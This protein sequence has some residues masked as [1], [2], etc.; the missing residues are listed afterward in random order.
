MAVHTVCPYWYRSIPGLNLCVLTYQIRSSLSILFVFIALQVTQLSFRRIP[1]S[2]EKYCNHAHIIFHI[3]GDFNLHLDTPSATTTTFID[4]LA[5]FDKKQ[6]VN[7]PTDIHGHWL[8]ILITRSSCKK[9][10]QTPTVADGLSDP[11]HSN[12]RFLKFQ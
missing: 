10:I 12:C 11:D 9:N 4:I 2:F 6:H 1:G 3:V 7:F 8:D 5:S